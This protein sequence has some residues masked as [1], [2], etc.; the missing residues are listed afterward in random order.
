MIKLYDFPLSGH[1]HRAR[2]LLSLLNIDYENIEVDLRQGQQKSAE[3][4]RL[5]PFGQIPVLVDGDVVIRDSNAI[6]VYIANKFAPDWNP[7]EPSDAG[8]VQ[9]WLTTASKEIAGGPGAARLVTVFKS[10]Q[11]HG[12]LIDQSHALLRQIDKHL[13]NRDW[14]A[15]DIPTIAD[16][17]AYSYI[18]TAPEGDVSLG[19]Y[20]SVRAWLARIE[21]LPG[22]VGMPSAFENSKAAQSTASQAA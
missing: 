16:V 15:L 8:Q 13:E 17:S 2:L 18:A 22:F 10:P 11:D 4:Q 12:K 7:S 21:A 1:G 14:L 20:P 3:F 5:N 9:A 19:A 6:L